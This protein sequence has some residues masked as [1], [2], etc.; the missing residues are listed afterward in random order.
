M[1]ELWNGDI[2]T[3]DKLLISCRLHSELCLTRDQLS[4]TN[5]AAVFYRRALRRLRAVLP[6]D[7]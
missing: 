5:A 1:R 2:S 3:E 7:W 6:G 4:E